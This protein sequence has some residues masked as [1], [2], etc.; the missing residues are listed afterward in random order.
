MGADKF[1]YSFYGLSDFR[2]L[3]FGTDLK[4]QAQKSSQILT[5]NT[6]KMNIFWR[7]QCFFILDVCHIDK[8]TTFAQNLKTPI[9][10]VHQNDD[11]YQ[12]SKIFSN[13]YFC[14]CSF[15]WIFS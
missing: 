1:H 3:N 11:C 14:T 5:S 2:N 8:K 10:Q 6:L 12:I 13:I 15:F 9:N 7:L 4:I